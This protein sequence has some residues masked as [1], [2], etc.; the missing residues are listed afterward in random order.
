MRHHLS[1]AHAFGG[2][3]PLQLQPFG[4]DAALLHLF[5]HLGHPFF[6][7]VIGVDVVVGDDGVEFTFGGAA[8]AAFK[9]VGDQLGGNSFGKAWCGP[10]RTTR[11][12]RN[13]K[14]RFHR[15]NV[16]VDIISGCLF[17]LVKQR[18]GFHLAVQIDRTGLAFFQVG[19]INGL[20][21][22]IAGRVWRVVS[23]TC[24]FFSTVKDVPAWC[25]SDKILHTG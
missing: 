1:K 2:T 4:P 13:L 14:M 20:H 9:L 5:A 19:C 16:L 6:G 24:L 22:F 25:R 23:R 21:D 18:K 8:A 12:S 17:R 11:L 10:V 3:D 15:I 7:P